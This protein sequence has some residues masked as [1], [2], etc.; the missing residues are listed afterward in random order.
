MEPYCLLT[1]PNSR[2]ESHSL[3]QRPYQPTHFNAIINLT[4]INTY[5]WMA[6]VAYRVSRPNRARM[7]LSG[8]FWY[9][10]DQM[11]DREI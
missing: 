10:T 3:R 9:D 1:I 5:T 7:F 4:L 8:H 2:F 6:Y 11:F